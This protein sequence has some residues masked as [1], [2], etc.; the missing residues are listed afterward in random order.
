MSISKLV[1][2]GE[3]EMALLEEAQSEG[4]AI[5]TGELIKR[6]IK[7]FPQLTHSELQRRTPSGTPWWPGRFRFDLNRLKKKG[8]IRSP[9]KGYWEITSLGIQRLAGSSQPSTQQVKNLSKSDK[10]VLDLIVETA[11]A[12]KKEQVPA[13]ITMGKGVFKIKLGKDIKKTKI[14]VVK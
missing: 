5:K 12:V 8:E 7:H 3:A 4:K 1:P 6:A 11:K 10:E 14:L 13:R 9:S 2:L